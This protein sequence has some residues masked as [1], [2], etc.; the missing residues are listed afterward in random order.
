VIHQ[1]PLRHSIAPR[2]W[3]LMNALPKSI[4]SLVAEKL[5]ACPG[6]SAVVLGGSVATGRADAGSDID[7]GLYYEPD[8]PLDLQRLSRLVAD[9]D[10]R[11]TEGSGSG[12]RGSTGEPGSWS[13]A[14]ESI[15]SIGTWDACVRP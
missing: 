10:D 8:S 3:F 4:A 9:I 14:T 2:E 7:I 12:G 1:C 5:A 6:M 11:R 13:G 15:C